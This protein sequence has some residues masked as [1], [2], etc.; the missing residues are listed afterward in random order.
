MHIANVKRLGV[1]P[2]TGDSAME[3]GVE[4][5]DCQKL[6]PE[7]KAAWQGAGHITVAR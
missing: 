5:K 2:L 1:A 7:R 6:G 3:G 4:Q